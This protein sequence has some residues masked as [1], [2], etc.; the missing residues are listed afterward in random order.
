MAIAG[1]MHTA[2]V[3]LEPFSNRSGYDSMGANVAML[4]FGGDPARV[5]RNSVSNPTGHTTAKVLPRLRKLNPQ[6]KTAVAAE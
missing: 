6:P 3:M 2:R 5:L 4:K 1:S